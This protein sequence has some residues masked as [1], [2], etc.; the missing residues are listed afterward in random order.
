MHRDAR[1]GHQ[2]DYPDRGAVVRD[3]PRGAAVVN[4]A[5]VSY[6]FSDGVWYEPR[7]PAF[8]V[9]APAIGLVVTSLP[10]FATTVVSHGQTYLYANDIYY[11]PQPE[12]GGYEVVNAPVDI[13][14]PVAAAPV[15]ATP[16][17]E[18]TASLAAPG[19]LPPA[20]GSPTASPLPP[21]TQPSTATAAI[22]STAPSAPDFGD[23]SEPA[24]VH[25]LA[26]DGA[27][28]SSP[29]A[30]MAEAA[31]VT[32][33]APETPTAPPSEVASAAAASTLASA[34]VSTPITATLAAP[35]QIASTPLSPAPPTTTLP[36]PAPA[37]L[38]TLVP[39][40]V[41]SSAPA[42]PS[43]VPGTSLYTYPRNGQS[44]DQ[45]ARDRYECYR[46]AVSQT[47][48]DPLR[49]TSGVESSPNV[50]RRSD[51]QR[52]QEACFEGLGYSVR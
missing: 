29:S 43:R 23:S 35:A 12:L 2:H 34:P 17:P 8:L 51:Y 52:A 33:A 24:M 38:P 15:S 50:N 42:V 28:A 32:T 31:P 14:S 16:T 21:S 25:P 20:A 6:R 36:P 22:T 45:Q 26:D 44:T 27:A 4:Y 13:D 18:V 7:G 3:L 48:Y 30:P 49:S 40:A 19:S 41:V 11:R 46:F 37:P 10:P 5:G 39:A 1:H 9:V 47:G